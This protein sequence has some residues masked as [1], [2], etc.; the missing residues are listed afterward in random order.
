[1]YGHCCDIIQHLSLLP[2]GAEVLVQIDRLVQLLET[3]AF[4]F[5]RLQLLQPSQHPDLLRAMY[6]LLMLLPQS[7]AFK[8]LAARLN[9]VPAVTLMQLE[10]LQQQPGNSKGSKQQQTQQQQQ[11]QQRQWADF[12]SLLK[13]F[14]SRQQEH[15][16]EEERRRLL[17]EGL[18]IEEDIQKEHIQ[19]AMAAALENRV[20]G[21]ISAGTG[22]AVA[23]PL[24]TGS[25]TSDGVRAV[26]H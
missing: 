10:T 12:D 11:Q 25:S 18:R 9:A 3:P 2:L 17:I 14:V 26:A 16:V 6:G 4:A 13:N 22:T 8:T 21:S 1:M 24:A 15:A 23:E 20:D 5:L 7:S 19:Q